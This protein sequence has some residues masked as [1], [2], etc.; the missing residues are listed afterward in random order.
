MTEHLSRL[1]KEKS[2]VIVLVKW[3]YPFFTRLENLQ[4]PDDCALIGIFA[5]E[6]RS[7]LFDGYEQHFDEIIWFHVSRDFS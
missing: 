5:E 2:K 7:K 3:R 4:K 1:N 6:I